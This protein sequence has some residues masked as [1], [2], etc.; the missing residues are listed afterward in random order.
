MPGRQGGRGAGYDRCV[1]TRTAPGSGGVAARAFAVAAVS[2]LVAGFGHA[3]GHGA[4]PDASAFLLTVVAAGGLGLVVARAGWTPLRLL[5]VLLAVQVAVHAAAWVSGGAGGA[6]DPRLAG[7]LDAAPAH[8][9]APFTL[10][11]LLA[12][13]AAVAAAAALLVAVDRA[14]RFLAH[15]ARRV[16]RPVRRA[17]VPVPARPVVAAQTRPLVLPAAPHLI[18]VRGN[19]PPVLLGIG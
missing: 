10:R 16:L 19:A 11:M 1:S 3:A 6:V 5:A 8:H 4:V 12:H 18:V 14:A 2:T 7:A 9:G 13:A 15:V 17:H